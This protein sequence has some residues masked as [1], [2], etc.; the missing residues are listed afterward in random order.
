MNTTAR[1]RGTAAPAAPSLNAN[2]A[3]VYLMAVACGVS[4]ANIYYA[5][6]LLDTLARSF[7]VSNS[8]AGLIVTMTQLGYAAG[9]MFLVPLGDLLERRRLIPGVSLC[10]ALALAGAA[11]APHIGVFVAA[12]LAVGLTA[13]VAQILVPFAA[14]LAQ[15]SQRGRVV[16]RVMSGL[17]LGILL[18]RVASGVIADALGWRSL[19]WIAS[20]LMLG[21]TLVL[22][23]VL[24]RTGA[25]SRLSYPGLLASVLA[26][27]RDEPLLRRRTA[28]GVLM[29]ASFSAMWT[30]LPF[31]LA[32]PS[33]GYSDAVIGLFGLLGAAGALCASFAGHLHDHGHTR[34]ATGGFMLL[35]VAAFAVLGVWGHH[36][37]AIVIGIILQDLG[38]Q[39]TQILNQSTIY[40]LRPEARSRITT[41]YMTL[42]FLGGA[43]GSALAAWFYGLWGWSGVSGLGAACG[44]LGLALWLTE[45]HPLRG[46]RTA[47]GSVAGTC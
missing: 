8:T 20:L 47:T 17:L 6:P 42:F 21:Q 43:A 11:A 24:P 26:L 29:F 45:F 33:Y 16:G 40:Q 3:L 32:G 25:V 14:H 44:V 37:A 1:R 13:V 34:P 18:A 38:M 12:S 15:D 35:I 41:A 27:L 31:L 22:W 28:Y 30:A 10:T 9:L 2:S 7:G 4:V 46:S 19:F 5:Q 23:R 39:G 36:L